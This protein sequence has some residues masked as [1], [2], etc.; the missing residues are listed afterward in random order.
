VGQDTQDT[1][2]GNIER[3]TIDHP[4]A[5]MLFFNSK[6]EQVAADDPDVN[7]QYLSDDPARPG[8]DRPATTILAVGRATAAPG[9]S[10]AVADTQ[11]SGETA[12]SDG[13]AQAEEAPVTAPDASEERPTG[14]KLTPAEAAARAREAKAAAAAPD[15]KA[16]KSAPAN[17]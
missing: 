2:G 6:G 16:V 5:E 13:G 10:G 8:A 4:P 7:T 12:S 9:S 15:T 11:P 17:K 1:L 14:Q 3:N